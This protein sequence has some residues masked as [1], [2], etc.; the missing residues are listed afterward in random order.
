MSDPNSAANPNPQDNQP[1][2]GTPTPSAADLAKAVLGAAETVARATAGDV[3]GAVKT[4][5]QT[6]SAVSSPKRTTPEDL[7]SVVPAPHI[8][9]L[10]AEPAVGSAAQI[11]D[12]VSN[13]TPSSVPPSD[14]PPDSSEVEA[15]SEDEEQKEKKKPGLG[16]RW[17]YIITR[18]LVVAIV[19]AFFAFLFDPIVRFGAVESAQR[20]AGAKVD[21]VE[22]STKFFPPQIHVG[23][24]AVANRN[25]PMTNLVEFASMSGDVDG[26]ALMKKSYILNKATITGLRWGTERTESGALADVDHPKD[27]KD[28]ESELLGKLEDAGKEWA[29]GLLDRAEMKYDPKNLETYVLADQLEDEWKTDFDD[30]ELRAKSVEAR[31][32]KLKELFNAAKRDPLRNLANIDQIVKDGVRLKAQ[33]QDIR[34]DVGRLPPKAQLDVNALNDARKRD[35]E[36]I[37]R[38]IKELILDET[39]LSEFLLGPETHHRVAQAMSWLKWT[40]DRVDR[41]KTTKPERTRGEDIA[42]NDRNPLPRFL[43]R[44]I[45]VTGEGEIA[46]DHLQIQGT[47]S[48]VT[49][50]P[51]LHGKPTIVRLEGTGE[52]AVKLH[53]TID[54]TKELPSNELNLSYNLPHATDDTLGDDDTFAVVVHANSTEWTVNLRT[55]DR[56]LHGTIVLKQK[57]VRLEARL[58]EGADERLRQVVEESVASVDEIQATVTLSG[59]VD[60]PKWKLRTTLGRQISRGVQRGMNNALTAEKTKLVAKLDGELKGRQEQFLGKLNGRYGDITKQL[61]LNDQILNEVNASQLIQR[62]SGG[63]FDP[64]KLFRR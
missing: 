27:E 44:L 8:P 64:T 43:A 51:V 22:F 1:Q 42:F 30:L 10:S 39:K 6:A 20:V 7:S 16:P 38:E 61:K 54:R 31:V 2:P 55:V 52:A 40:D 59:T 9:L 17:S 46:G 35:T 4:G 47:I 57:P 25:E 28:G 21:V 62:V 3:P 50:N 19:W 60:D 12:A 37:Q 58:K 24:L 33:L 36:R 18:C 48:D 29:K 23:H 5:L 63:K 56:E 41:M 13:P 53:A 34:T 11:A 32:K 26:L 45:E 14:V 15:T 49:D